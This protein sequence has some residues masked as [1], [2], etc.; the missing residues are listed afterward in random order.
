LRGNLQPVT[1]ALAALLQALSPAGP[2]GV[3]GSSQRGK[4]G[5]RPREWWKFAER[6]EARSRHLA[7]APRLAAVGV[8]HRN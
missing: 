8:G 3:D 5:L 7:Q 1:R 4:L 2:Q 6:G